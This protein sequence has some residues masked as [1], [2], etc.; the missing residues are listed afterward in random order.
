MKKGQVVK[1]YYDPITQKELEGKARLIRQYRPDSGDGLEMW[2]CRF[3][4]ARGEPVV[5][6]TIKIS[7]DNK[8]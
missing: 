3:S 2:E 1:I 6:R 5:L 7:I 4:D 8:E